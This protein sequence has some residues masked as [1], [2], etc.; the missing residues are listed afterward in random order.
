MQLLKASLPFL[1]TYI[2]TINNSNK[3]MTLMIVYQGLSHTVSLLCFSTILIVPRLAVEEVRAQH[4]HEVGGQWLEQLE[5]EPRSLTAS[6]V[7]S[8]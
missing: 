3:S 8:P 4:R 6:P 2:S 5:P 7:V 1:F